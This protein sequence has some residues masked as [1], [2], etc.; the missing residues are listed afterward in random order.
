MALISRLLLENFRNH[1]NLELNTKARLV[2]ISG[3]NGQGKTNIIEAISL[4][5]PGRGI[6]GDNI[7]NIITVNSANPA[8]AIFC[9][10]RDNNISNEIGLSYQLRNQKSAKIIK[11]N[12]ATFQNSKPLLEYLKVI[13]LTPQM[14]DILSASNTTK[15]KFIDR[16]TFNFFS[17]HAASVNKFEQAYK[18]RLKL[19]T[20]NNFDDSWLSGLERVIAEES[21]AITQRRQECLSIISKQL[22]NFTSSFIKPTLNLQGKIES[23]LDAND[24]ITAIQIIKEE[25]K[26][27]RKLDAIRKRSSIGANRSEL[28]VLHP[29]KKLLSEQCSTGEQKAMLLSIIIAQIRSLNEVFNI[30]P[31][32]LLDDIFSHLDYEV[33]NNLIAELSDLR[34]QIWITA[35]HIDDGFLSK[36]FSDI[37]KIAI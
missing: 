11:I 3:A 27:A 10:L 2:C 7:G 12:S 26:N 14:D 22:K 33:V 34:A 13:W 6:R 23:W 9:E 5:S 32:L 1:S 35:T 28:M 37:V 25:L 18:S 15:L 16:V 21:V 17:T 30:E 29:I 19:L 4:L 31:V 24:N 20:D 8:C 36:Y